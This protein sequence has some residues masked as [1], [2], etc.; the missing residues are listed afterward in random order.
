MN[1]VRMVKLGEVAKIERK[2]IKPEN[3]DL[4]A[5][6]IGLEHIRKG[7]RIIG[8]S[9]VHE[10]SVQSSKFEFTSEHILYGKL[11]PYLAKI[12]TPDFD[13][14][15]STDILPIRAGEKIDK[16]YLYFYLKK[17]D[18]VALANKNTT[19]ANLPRI[20][21]KALEELPIKLPPLEEQK[22]I[23]S[24]ERIKQRI[25]QKRERQRELLAELEKSVF[26]QMFGDGTPT[27]TVEDISIKMRTGPFGSQLL[28][29]EFTD[30]G[31]SVL[32]IDNVVN[33][34][35]E[36]GKRRFI[37]EEKYNSLQRYTVSPGDV[38][39][40]IMGTV[41]RCAVAPQDIP[42]AINTKHLC[43]ITADTNKVFPEYLQKYFLISENSKRYLAQ[44]T[45]GA[46][47]SG[48]N[49]SIIKKI[50][51]FVPPTGLQN[52]FISIIEPINCQKN[53]IERSHQWKS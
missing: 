12:L 8:R 7:G 20:S 44:Q 23:A 52:Q 31:I 42:V 25:E 19:G 10:S 53:L 16:D 3:L 4:Q 48:L 35:F 14:V 24:K 41:G 15:C 9:T 26:H 37:S 49:M 32:G 51:I 22:R 18:L 33:N 50:P 11:R 36:W 17:P 28:H 29:S 27:H 5:T 30:E 34:K 38:L 43:C 47:M 13:G 39:V 40:S 6:Y 21:P 45:K 1:N 2:S 46:I